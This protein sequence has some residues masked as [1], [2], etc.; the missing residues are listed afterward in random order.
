MAEQ[1]RFKEVFLERAAIQRHEILFRA[2]AAAVHLLRHQFLSDAAFALDQHGGVRGGHGF[3]HFRHPENGRAR[4]DHEAAFRGLRAASQELALLA[5]VGVF[6]RPRDGQLQ[7]VEVDRLHQVFRGPAPNGLDGALHGTERGEDD[8]RILRGQFGKD[9][10]AAGVGQLNVEQDQ[11]RLVLPEKGAS[12]PPGMGAGGVE[13]QIPQLL[14]DKL[15][16]NPIIFDDEDFLAFAAAHIQCSR[17]SGSG[18]RTVMQVPL[19]TSLFA[20]SLPS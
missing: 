1:F 14:A 19:P 11:R 5:Q 4:S 15:I 8:H 13:A 2:Q 12:L 10:Q 7:L 20:S 17:W 16:E 6:Q 18:K 9:L 3:D